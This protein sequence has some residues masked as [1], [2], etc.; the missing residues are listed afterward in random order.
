MP[1][2]IEK[3]TKTFEKRYPEIIALGIA[4]TSTAAYIYNYHY[5]I[6]QDDLTGLIAA[7]ALCCSG[8]KTSRRNAG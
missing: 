8:A 1:K 6:S 7:S 3:L 2:A 4:M 5:S